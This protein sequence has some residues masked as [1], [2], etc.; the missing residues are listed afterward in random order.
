MHARLESAVKV[1]FKHPNRPEFSCVKTLVLN[2]ADTP[3]VDSLTRFIVSM[4]P[5]D[6]PTDAEVCL[7]YRGETLDGDMA[8]ELLEDRIAAREGF[9]GDSMWEMLE[10]HVVPK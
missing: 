3:T 5:G 1:T 8:V 6:V 9:S 7:R 4:Y 2:N 10:V